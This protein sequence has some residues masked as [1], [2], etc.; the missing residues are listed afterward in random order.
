MPFNMQ[1]LANCLYVYICGFN[2]K[3]WSS[4]TTFA[5]INVAQSMEG[6]RF[7]RI[8]LHCIAA[9]KLRKSRCNYINLW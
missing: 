6:G 1:T 4:I 8:S 9:S 5:K 7:L 3:A 2:C